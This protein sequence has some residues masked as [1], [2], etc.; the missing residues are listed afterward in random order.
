[1]TCLLFDP[2]RKRLAKSVE[3]AR[4]AF[5]QSQNLRTILGDEFYEAVLRTYGS[6]QAVDPGAGLSTEVSENI[7]AHMAKVDLS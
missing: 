1:M 3:E 6:D 7:F 4:N 5:E 2:K